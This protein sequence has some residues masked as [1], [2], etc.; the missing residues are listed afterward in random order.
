MLHFLCAQGPILKSH[1][2]C[3]GL[4]SSGL[5]GLFWASSTPYLRINDNRESSMIVHFCTF[6]QPSKSE[7]SG[8][9]QIVLDGNT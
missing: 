3:L 9:Y 1:F 2:P 6:Q 5:P 8:R 4:S 7:V